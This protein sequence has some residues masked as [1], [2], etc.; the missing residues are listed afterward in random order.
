[1]AY[2]LMWVCF[3][4]GLG[5]AIVGL[6]GWRQSSPRRLS[7]VVDGVV[8]VS[9]VVKECRESVGDDGAGSTWYAYVA[10]VEY[11]WQDGDV[12][13]RSEQ[14]AFERTDPAFADPWQAR[15]FLRRYPA[16]ATVRVHVHPDDPSAS[17]LEPG[18]T[19][20]V[21]VCLWAAGVCGAAAAACA[22]RAAFG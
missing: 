22:A 5:F 11:A 16:G 19:H 18:P 1:M 15:A 6:W 14:I 12:T 9:E 10:R 3:S 17:V 13:R 2:G 7:R 8:V 4:I 21:R 20:P